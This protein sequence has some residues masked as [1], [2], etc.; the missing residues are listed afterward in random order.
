MRRHGGGRPRGRE[1][2]MDIRTVLTLALV[3]LVLL[4]AAAQAFSAPMKQLLKAALNTI[5]GLAA[6]LVLN[7]TSSLTGLSLG[8]NLFNALVVGVL[9]VPGL[10][11]LLLVQWVLT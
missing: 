10:V 4:A 2:Q 3:G 7:A 1:G 9:G 11:L 8:F 6:L 5:L